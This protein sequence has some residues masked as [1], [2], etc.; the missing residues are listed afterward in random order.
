VG[1]TTRFIDDNPQ[2][3]QSLVDAFVAA[4]SCGTVWYI[5]GNDDGC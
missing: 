5:S 3:C 1:G 4:C 2:L